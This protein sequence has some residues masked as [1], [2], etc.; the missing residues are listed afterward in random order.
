[1]NVHI[2]IRN[3]SLFYV[4]AYAIA[5]PMQTWANKKRGQPFDD[6]EFLFR[7][8]TI[9]LLAM[10]W[11]VTGLI[12]SLFVPIISGS[13]FI[14]GLCFYVGGLIVTAFAFYSFAN[15]RGLVT[16]GIHRY[17]RNP[18]YVGWVLVLFGLTL[19]GWSASIVSV[20]F[21]I[22]FILTIPYFHWTVLLEEKF[23]ASKYGD[24]YRQYLRS[25]SRYF[26]PSKRV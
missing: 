1:M 14:V 20:L 6:P 7:G 22:Y 26:G 11:L 16:T 3:L 8:K 18:F 5:L 25:S 21:L 23:L 4:L 24:S 19:I 10:L 12:I 13:L 15:H 2:G 9:F 17:S